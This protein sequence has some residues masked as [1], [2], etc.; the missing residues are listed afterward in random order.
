MTCCTNVSRANGFAAPPASD[1]ATLRQG[2]SR[3][4]RSDVDV[5]HDQLG[6]RC[7]PRQ[8]PHEFGVYRFD[9]LETGVGHGIDKGDADDVIILDKQDTHGSTPTETSAMFPLP[10]YLYDNNARIEE[11]GQSQVSA[12]TSVIATLT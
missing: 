1:I 2:Q 5:T 9:D 10:P 11:F 3:S 8:R 7:R 4:Y 6:T 12:S